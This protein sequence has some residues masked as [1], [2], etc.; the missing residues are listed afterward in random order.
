MREHGERPT[1]VLIERELARFERL[2]AA[3]AAV[4]AVEEAGGTAHYYSVDLTDAG[5]VGR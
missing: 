4:R 2:Q 5:A 3:L 1:P